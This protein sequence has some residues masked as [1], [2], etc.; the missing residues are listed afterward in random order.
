MLSGREVLRVEWL[1]GSDVL[2]G[3]CHCGATRSADGPVEVWDWLLSHPAGHSPAT[4]APERAAS[5]GTTR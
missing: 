3:R 1:P 4:A 5:S 2:Q